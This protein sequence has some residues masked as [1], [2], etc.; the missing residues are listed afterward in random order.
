MKIK[1]YRL[2]KCAYNTL[3]E[4]RQQQQHVQLRIKYATRTTSYDDTLYLRHSLAM[5]IAT[6]FKHSIVLEQVLVVTRPFFWHHKDIS[7]K[8]SG[9]MH[10]CYYSVGLLYLY[11][12]TI[13]MIFY[14]NLPM[15]L[16]AYLQQ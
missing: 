2:Y 5:C 16:F 4:I 14:K 6:R 15:F 3:K 9:S 8:V 10:N 12:M 11:E 1:W 7:V 13:V